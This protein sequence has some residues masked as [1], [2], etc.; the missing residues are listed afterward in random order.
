MGKSNNKKI[1]IDASFEELVKMSVGDNP[2]PKEKKKLTPK[3]QAN[4]TTLL[5]KMEAAKKKKAGG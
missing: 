5:I 2:K 3:Q 4:L 1:K